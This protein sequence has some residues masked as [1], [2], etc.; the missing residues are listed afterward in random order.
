MISDYEH[1]RRTFSDDMARRLS[2]VLEV[3]EEQLQYRSRRSDDNS[4]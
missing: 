2:A 4:Q 1:G 3:R